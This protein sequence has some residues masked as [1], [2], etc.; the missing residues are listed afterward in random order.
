MPTS[1]AANQSFSSKSTARPIRRMK[2][3]RKTARGRFLWSG[4]AIGLF[5]SAISRFTNRSIACATPSLLRSTT[6]S[7]FATGPSPYLSPLR[8]ERRPRRRVPTSAL[9]FCNL[10]KILAP[11]RRPRLSAKHFQPLRR[12]DDVA[13][14]ERVVVEQGVHWARLLVLI[15]FEP[16]R[17]DAGEPV[18][19]AGAGGFDLGLPIGSVRLLWRRILCGSDAGAG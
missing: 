5:A 1:P 11:M 4:A 2:R 17:S 7:A 18:V 16:P 13:G 9:R 12:R 6:G 15:A 19:V 10:L 14:D 3:L 8:G